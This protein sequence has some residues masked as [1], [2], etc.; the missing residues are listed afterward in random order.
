VVLLLGTGCLPFFLGT[1]PAPDSVP[2]G[3]VLQENVLGDVASQRIWLVIYAILPLL[4]ALRWRWFIRVATSDKL[5]VLLVVIVVAS[6]LWSSLPDITFRRSLAF[7]GTSL[8]GT[9]LVARY[10]SKALLELAAWALGIG[11]L[12]SLVVALVWPHLGIDATGEWQ[13]IYGQKNILGRIMALATLV[14][15]FLVASRRQHHKLAWAGLGLSFGLVVL[16]N[17]KTSLLLSLSVVFFLFYYSRALR[18][19]QNLVVPS[20]IF[21]CVLIAGTAVWFT[22]SEAALGALGKEPTLS[23]RTEIWSAVL[24]MIRHRPWLG[25]GYEGFWPTG[26]EGPAGYVYLRAGWE[27]PHAHS[28]L[29]DTWLS[30]GLMGLAVLGAQFFLA[31]LR[32]VAWARRTKTVEGLWPIVFLTFT[33]LYNITEGTFLA[34]NNTLWMLY[35]AACLTTFVQYPRRSTSPVHAAAPKRARVLHNSR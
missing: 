30:L 10:N 12:L 25:Y 16:S 18:G 23:S 9:Y 21:I 27:V 1:Q 14:F 22:K 6:T 3:A 28:G 24:D 2:G 29:L 34:R 13:G 17:S 5:L 31:S 26:W 35:V 32:A 8:F 15:A 4:I 7:V 20:L 19:H 33:I 11:A